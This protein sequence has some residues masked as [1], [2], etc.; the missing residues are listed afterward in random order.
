MSTQ[1]CL[2]PETPNRKPAFLIVGVSGCIPIG[3]EQV[4]EPGIARIGL[5]RTPPATVGANEVAMTT[6]VAVT[7]R[8]TSK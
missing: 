7:A 3:V 6:A 2:I 4:A 8:K 5:R 1:N